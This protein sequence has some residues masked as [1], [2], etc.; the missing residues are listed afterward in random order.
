MNSQFSLDNRLENDTKLICSMN[1]CDLRLLDDS[2]W[3]WLV[4]IPRIANAVELHMLDAQ[5]QSAI[6]A[7]IMSV[8]QALHK[9]FPNTKINTGAL[10]NM[11]RQLHIHIIARCENDAN[12]PGP[13]WGVAGK[14]AYD[15]EAAFT[16]M[17]KIKHAL[18]NDELN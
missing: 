14:T 7:E 5:S 18:G 6:F 9:I 10:G 8:S 11:V 2:R 1:I 3:P 13:V 15:D 4:L 12:W 17:D 16:I